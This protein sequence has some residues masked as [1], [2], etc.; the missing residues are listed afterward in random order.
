MKNIKV[1]GTIFVVCMLS[2]CMMFFTVKADN[3]TTVGISQNQ[4]VIAIGQQFILNVVCVPTENVKGY[5]FGFSFDPTVIRVDSVEEGD[6]FEEYPT[7]FNPGTIYNNN[8]TVESIYGLILGQGNTSTSGNL[9]SIH[10]T[11]L[12]LDVC[13]LNLLDVGLVNY[14]QY[15]NITVTNTTL[16]VAYDYDINQDGVIDIQD[17]LQVAL[18]Y[19]EKGTPG[20]LR[21]DIDENGVVNIRDLLVVSMHY[22]ET[23]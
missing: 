14:S 17:I 12:K 1:L 8:G 2:F 10:C 11:S 15:I 20:W 4:R 13:Q 5:E 19:G 7:F 9:V 18:H 23:S 21:V 22:G 3:N 16:H 6:F